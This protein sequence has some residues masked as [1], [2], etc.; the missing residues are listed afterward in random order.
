M[1]E[2]KKEQ[3]E[4]EVRRK[5]INERKKKEAEGKCYYFFV[6]VC[7]LVSQCSCVKTTER[8]RKETE[9]RE[10]KTILRLTEE[11]M[12]MAKEKKWAMKTLKTGDAAHYPRPGDSVRVHYEMRL[13]PEGELIDSS[14]KRLQPFHFMVGQKHVIEGMDSAIQKMSVGQEILLVVMPE[15]AYGKRGFPPLVPGDSTLIFKLHLLS[16][17]SKEETQEM[18][19]ERAV[20]KL[21]YIKNGAGDGRPTISEASR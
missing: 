9:I 19:Q 18:Q 2:E 7:L 13:Y 14:S 6:C 3:R 12:D 4:D 15:F 21:D 10:R 16:Y 1:N 8:Q 5:E 11:I 20:M 17:V